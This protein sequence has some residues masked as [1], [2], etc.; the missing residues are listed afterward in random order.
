MCS[1]KSFRGCSVARHGIIWQKSRQSEVYFSPS[2]LLYLYW[3]ARCRR[4]LHY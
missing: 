2:G 4:P 3:E 1:F